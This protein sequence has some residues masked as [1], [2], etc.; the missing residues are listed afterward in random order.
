MICKYAKSL[1]IDLNYIIFL[2]LSLLFSYSCIYNR[3]IKKEVLLNEIHIER[4]VSRI[5]IMIFIDGSYSENRILEFEN[6]KGVIENRTIYN[7]EGIAEYID[8]GSAE[9]FI[10]YSLFDKVGCLKFDDYMKDYYI[11]IVKDENIIIDKHSKSDTIRE[12]VN[13]EKQKLI[14]KIENYKMLFEPYGN[15]R[16]VLYYYI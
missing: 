4:I 11:K 12:F 6:I 8:R 14:M 13:Y 1:I 15:K 16:I 3:P 5:E 10:S 7:T 9:G 2:L